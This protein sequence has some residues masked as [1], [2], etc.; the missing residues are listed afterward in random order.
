MPELAQR[1]LPGM[2][3]DEFGRWVALKHLAIDPEIREVH[4]LPTNAAPR[5][6]RLLEVN[7]R[8]AVSGSVGPVEP[9]DFMPDVNG[10]DFTLLVADVTP[11]EWEA[12]RRQELSL[13]DG[14]VVD[15]HTRTFGRQ[16]P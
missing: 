4:Y 9:V 12:I 16:R 13:P 10:L 14:W 7:G 11:E 8:L 2:S 6:V 5:E 15:D 3:R 1:A